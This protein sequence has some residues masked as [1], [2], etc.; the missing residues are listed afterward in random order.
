MFFTTKAFNYF[1]GSEEGATQRS[2]T[3]VVEEAFFSRYFLCLSI[4]SPR[5]FPPYSGFG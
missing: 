3:L 2:Y 5:S 4:L 1:Y